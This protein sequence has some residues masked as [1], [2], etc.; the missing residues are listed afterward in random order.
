MATKKKSLARGRTK[1]APQSSRTASKR[2]V[3]SALPKS[4]AKT[5][6]G[7]LSEICALVLAE[8]RRLSMRTWCIS[9]DM[10]APGEDARDY[11]ARG[12]PSCG[13][14][15]CIGG[16]TETLRP[17]AAARITLGIDRDLG[18]ELFY[19]RELL[20]QRE[21]TV[22]HARATVAHIRRFQRK[23]AAQL[24]AHELPKGG[25]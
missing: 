20:A 7:V 15:G 19:P 25:A 2:R 10:L 3:V 4:K 13:T 12:F 11:V 17:D 8:P 24:K 18:E 22:A 6:H 1:G 14:V 21:Q 5:A 9:R 16:W 23:Y